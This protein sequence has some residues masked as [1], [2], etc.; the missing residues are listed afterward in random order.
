MDD[1][2][3]KHL[4]MIQNV[5]T[6]MANNSFMLKGWTITLLVAALALLWDK[7]DN[8]GY[9]CLLILPIVAFWLLDSYYL[10]QERLYRDLYNKVIDPNTNI[11][12]FSM[13]PQPDIGN[14]KFSYINVIFSITERYFYIPLIIIVLVTI[15]ILY[16][17]SLSIALNT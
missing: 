17:N 15:I 8:I 12:S 7:C 9:L 10:R 1:N 13:I 14:K 6:R 5:I 2:K 3:I 11:P 4:E 16:I